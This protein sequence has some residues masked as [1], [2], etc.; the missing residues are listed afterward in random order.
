[1]Y[2]HSSKRFR[3]LQR[4]TYSGFTGSS[5]VKTS[6]SFVGEEMLLLWRGSL[7]PSGKAVVCGGGLVRVFKEARVLVVVSVQN[8][9]EFVSAECLVTA[10]EGTIPGVGAVLLLSGNPA[11]LVDSVSVGRWVVFSSKQALWRSALPRRGRKLS[12]LGGALSPGR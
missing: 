7:T 3:V 10:R 8:S 4:S 12:P 9:K 6:V 1:M 5:G 11:V 2:L